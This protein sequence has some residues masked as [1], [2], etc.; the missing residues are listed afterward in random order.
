MRQEEISTDAA[1]YE[2]LALSFCL[3]SKWSPEPR[4]GTS[5]IFQPVLELSEFQGKARLRAVND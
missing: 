5:P 2:A 1:A 3:E 4:L